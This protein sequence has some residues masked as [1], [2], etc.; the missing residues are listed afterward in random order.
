MNGDFSRRTFDATKHYSAVLVE[1]GRLLTDADSEEEHRILT[2]RTER[3]TEDIVG[4]CGGPLPDAGFA[5]SAPDG[6]ELRIGAG[7]YYAAG[8]LLENESE[9]AFPDQPDR[10]DVPWPLPAGRHAVVLDSW[11]RLVTALDDPSI[12]EVALGGP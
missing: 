3:A 7:R 10:Y 12:R 1:Q 8:A 11:R 4:G 9:V 6:A 2:H 5:L